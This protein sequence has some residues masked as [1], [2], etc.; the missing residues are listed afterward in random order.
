MDRE[1]W[2]AAV[3]GVAESNMTE[4]LN[5]TER[6]KQ[7]CSLD[8]SFIHAVPSQNCPCTSVYV[9]PS[10]L[11]YPSIE[12]LI[13][14]QISAD[15]GSLGSVPGTPPYHCGPAQWGDTA[16]ASS[17][18]WLQYSLHGIL[19]VMAFPS[20]NICAVDSLKTKY[21]PCVIY[22]ATWNRTVTSLVL[23]FTSL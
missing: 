6:N 8:G 21:R 5:W 22:W 12:L 3:H 20:L 17:G 16:S 10:G 2:R 15:V 19:R 4:R 14:F 7:Q 11:K 23:G 9:W 13:I 1:A 18:L